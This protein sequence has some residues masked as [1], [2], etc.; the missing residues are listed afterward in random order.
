LVR[1]LSTPA[2][3]GI[4]LYNADNNANA[5]WDRVSR[6]PWRYLKKSVD[7][8]TGEESFFQGEYW[9]DPY[10]ESVWRYNTDIARE[11]EDRGGRRGTT[12][13]VVRLD[14]GHDADFAVPRYA[15]CTDGSAWI[16]VGVPCAMT[17]PKSS[18][19]M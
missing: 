7:S 3:Q 9:V 16:S 14:G 1:T 6:A 17:R 11:L 10:S 15:R 8:D 19:L 12:G 5:V 4:Q 18:T 13:C 2:A